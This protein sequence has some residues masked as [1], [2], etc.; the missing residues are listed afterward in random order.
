MKIQTIVPVFLFSVLLIAGCSSP[1]KVSD[2][3]L[4]EV[5]NVIDG[6]KDVAGSAAS[7]V[8]DV[9]GGAVD[10]AENLTEGAA[11]GVESAVEAV[12]E[13]I[14]PAP[15]VEVSED[16]T[17]EV[18]GSYVLVPESST[19]GWVGKKIGS[20]H[21]GTID[22]AVGD[23]SIVDGVGNGSFV[24][25]MTTIDTLDLSGRSKEGMDNHLKN[26]DFF[27]VTN[28]PEAKFV[29]KDIDVNGASGNA[30]VIGDLTIKGITN[31]VDFSA[32]YVLEGDVYTV[33]ADLQ[34]DRTLWD[35]KY[36]SAK[37]FSGIAD[38]AIKDEID[39]S[40][41]LAFKKQ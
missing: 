7:G 24:M 15:G 38:K 21:N 6:V 35:I 30:D 22:I 25:D 14:A 29:L 10:V 28:H 41:D 23:L 13:A 32:S 17:S 16:A 9:A 33:S 27:D 2:V 19:L 3:N 18:D 4:P 5:P 20:Q 39:L 26:E 12:E 36:N 31:P 8:V 1:V 11:E 34:I 40:L 37:F